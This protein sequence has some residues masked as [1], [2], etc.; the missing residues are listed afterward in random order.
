MRVGCAV[1]RR[2]MQEGESPGSVPL[3]GVRGIQFA[4]DVPEP[5]VAAAQFYLR[6]RTE[7]RAGLGYGLPRSAP[8]DGLLREETF[9]YGP[10]RLPSPEW[11]G[12]GIARDPVGMR[13]WRRSLVPWGGVWAA[14]GMGLALSPRGPGGLPWVF[15]FL[16]KVVGL[17]GLDLATNIEHRYL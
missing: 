1:R 3:A 4:D 11:S 16:L 9:K 2:R 13:R 10:G 15:W 6:K 17:G 5:G 7:S 14:V 8:W 12:K